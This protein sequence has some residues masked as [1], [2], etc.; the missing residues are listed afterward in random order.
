MLGAVVGCVILAI[1]QQYQWITE[2]TSSGA[3]SARSS[4]LASSAPRLDQSPLTTER[5]QPQSIAARTLARECS[6]CEGLCA[7]RHDSARCTMC[8]CSTCGDCES[9]RHDAPLPSLSPPP[10]PHPAETACCLLPPPPPAPMPVQIP[11]RWG[12]SLPE[13]ELLPR[14]QA[15]GEPTPKE[16]I[17][18]VG[19]LAIKKKGDLARREKAAR[20]AAGAPEASKRVSVATETVRALP[21]QQL[22]QPS[23]HSECLSHVEGGGSLPADGTS[24]SSMPLATSA[25][26]PSYDLLAP[27]R[28]GKSR[29][30]PQLPD[31]RVRISPTPMLAIDECSCALC[32]T[33][34][35]R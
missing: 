6:Q 30:T 25:T 33:H 31:A 10:P 8:T 18:R 26:A 12:S 4:V 34:A 23:A 21:L 2:Q 11:G 14:Q 7:S 24:Q 28:V 16:S 29:S 1:A 17:Q 15:P 20:N 27:T 13:S 35:G 32:S 9:I 3:I 22:D 5:T 19:K